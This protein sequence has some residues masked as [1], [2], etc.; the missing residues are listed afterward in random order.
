MKLGEII[1]L[2]VGLVSLV[3][4]GSLIT[5]KLTS[6]D[7][8]GSGPGGSGPGGS[9]PGGSGPGGSG[10][11]GSGPGGSG[12]EDI[13]LTYEGGTR[14]AFNLTMQ[15]GYNPVILRQSLINYLN[16]HPDKTTLCGPGNCVIDKLS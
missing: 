3:A 12:T 5:D 7:T 14:P 1:L 11:G 9:G 6:S 15:Q 10:P 13:T 4:I 8:G 16:T 2:C